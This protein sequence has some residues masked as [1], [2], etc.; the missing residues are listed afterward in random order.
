MSRI[1]Y[2]DDE[3]F[4]GQFALWQANCRR[5]LRSKRGRAALEELEAALVA[6]PV[7]RLIRGAIE[8]HGEVCAV[9]A[10]IR[11]RGLLAEVD[12]CE[13][14]D[15]VAEE[16]LG[17][18]R[19]VAWKLVELNDESLAHDTPEERYEHV[20]AYVRKFLGRAHTPAGGP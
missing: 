3:E 19:L 15:E 9:G 13:L 11:A 7:K 12:E 2:S 5:S 20:L 1:N 18:P 6:M 8:K 17:Y 16:L 14:T 4:G 10:V